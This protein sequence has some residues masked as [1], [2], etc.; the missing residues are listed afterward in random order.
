MLDRRFITEQPD[1]VRASLTKRNADEGT[2]AALE[3]IIEMDQHRK[4]VNT[5]TDE[6]R[7]TRN[8][9]SRQI[10]PLMQQGKR[11]EA[12]P[13]KAQVKAQGDRLAA[14]ESELKELEASQTA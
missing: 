10:G 3:Q 12:E 4:N 1:V 11:D 8:S 6:L 13:L 14:L 7:A 5:E 9:L 2:I